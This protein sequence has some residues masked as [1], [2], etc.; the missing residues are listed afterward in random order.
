MGRSAGTAREALRA[1]RTRFAANVHLRLRVRDELL[2]VVD[3]SLRRPY[4]SVLLPRSQDDGPEPD[5]ARAA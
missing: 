3:A 2:L 5:L 4:V 1:A